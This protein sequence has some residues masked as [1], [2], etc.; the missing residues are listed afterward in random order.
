[1]RSLPFQEFVVVTAAAALVVDLTVAV[2]AVGVRSLR[3]QEVVGGRR[4]NRFL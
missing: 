2:G 4:R 3:F 1:V